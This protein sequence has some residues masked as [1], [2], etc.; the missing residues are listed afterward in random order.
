MRLI[1]ELYIKLIKNL[2]INKIKYIFLIFLLSPFLIF[3]VL[4]KPVFFVRFGSLG[5]ERIGN[6]SSAELYLLINKFKKK[7]LNHLIFG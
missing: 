4:I 2:T 1:R 7:K 3:I 5:C 6:F